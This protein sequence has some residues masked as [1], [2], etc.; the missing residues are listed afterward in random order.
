MS[1]WSPCVQDIMVMNWSV[2]LKIS[3]FFQKE[4]VKLAVILKFYCKIMF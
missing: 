3:S 1:S 2:S 4:L